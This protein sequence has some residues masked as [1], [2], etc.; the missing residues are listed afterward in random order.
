LIRL[1]NFNK[2]EITTI[3]IFIIVSL[4]YFFN[5]NTNPGFGDDLSFT[6]SALGNFDIATNATNHFLFNIYNNILV[7]LFFFIPP[8]TLLTL[9]SIIF[10][11]LTLLFI[12]KTSNLFINDDN[13][14]SI[15]TII[16]IAFSFTY[17][18]QSE[19]IEV[20]TF[21]NFFFSLFIY[22]TTYNMIK[23][24]DEKSIQVG[25]TLGILFLIHIQN[26]LILPAYIIYLWLQYKENSTIR[27]I[28]FPTISAIL[29]FSILL[30]IPI[31]YNTN[32]ISSIFFD[33][34]FRDEVLNLEISLIAKGFFKSI[35]FVIYNFTIFN[36]FIVIGVFK[37]YKKNR[38]IFYYLSLLLV[39][40]WVFAMR[41]NVSDNYVFFLPAYL[42]L[43]IFLSQ[44]L[45]SLR[46]TDLKIKFLKNK[47]IILIIALSFNPLS[48]YVTFSITKKIDRLADFNNRFL[49]K[50]GL[51]YYIWPGLN[52]NNALFLDDAKNI[53]LKRKR[54]L[55]Y[56]EGIMKYNYKN[57][58]N[59]LIIR[60]EIIE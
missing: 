8:I 38:N 25:V 45:G 35:L 42:V 6:V 53:Y 41:Y 26:I 21:N 39:T 52:Y 23:K 48:Y 57:A 27:P 31:I 1:K 46:K 15:L 55:T 34:G 37:I 56:P 18:R 9:S 29:L 58:I 32:T 59:Y 30:F 28:L 16:I 10:S 40:F 51:K 3:T 17:W 44:G 24:T 43:A 7:D 54:N 50:G 47:Y 11:I 33:N 49:Y 12:F 4:I 13:I 60:K 22:Y 19:I 14:S 20:Y 5:R 2:N 36:I